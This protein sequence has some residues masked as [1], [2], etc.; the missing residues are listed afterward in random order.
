MAEGEWVDFKALKQTIS[1]QM[2][3]DHYKVPGLKRVG[4]E[5]RGPCPIHKGASQSRH[6]CV[7][8]TKNAFKC[9]AQSCKARG[10]ILDFVAAMENCSVR[11]SALKLK[12][13]FLDGKL[14]DPEPSGKHEPAAATGGEEPVPDAPVDWLLKLVLQSVMEELEGEITQLTEQLKLKQHRLA[15]LQK[16]VGL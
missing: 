2:V 7:S 9:F 10:N 16:V 11:D 12:T 15:E 1:M 13:I 3:L 14:N 4:D 6:F 8:L 5:L